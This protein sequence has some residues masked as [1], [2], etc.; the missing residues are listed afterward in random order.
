MNNM[1]RVSKGF[2]L[3]ELMIVIAIIAIL[4]ALALPAYQ[5]YTIRAKTA[6]GLSLGAG[7]KL[8][9]SETCQ[10]D[11]A[12]DLASESGYSFT[13]GTGDEDY[14]NNIVITDGDCD[15]A[16]AGPVITITID[17][18]KV[19]RSGGANFDLI[20]TGDGSLDGQFMWTCTSDGEDQH[21]PTSCRGS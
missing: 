18:T 20:L 7:P 6:E 1:K 3:I 9:V 11:P 12:A 13:A 14:V 19:G 15:S 5:D 21:V 16:T 17:G 4:L 2:T 8:A 10:S